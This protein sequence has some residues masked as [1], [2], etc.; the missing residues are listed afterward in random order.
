MSA[1]VWMKQTSHKIFTILRHNLENKKH[2]DELLLQISE[3]ISSS[4]VCYAL[5]PE[6]RAFIFSNSPKAP[7]ERIQLFDQY[8]YHLDI[9]RK[10]NRPTL[11]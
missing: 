6:G 11:G 8:M 9:L 1:T 4:L 2:S 3:S 10:T 7:I 5:T